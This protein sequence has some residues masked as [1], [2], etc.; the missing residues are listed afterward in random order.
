MNSDLNRVDAYEPKPEDYDELPELTDV[1][2]D[3]RSAKHSV[4]DA[5]DYLN[6]DTVIDEYLTA[7]CEDENPDVFLQAVADV[8]KA[9]GEPF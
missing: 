6:E 2:L 8:A 7:A 1:M 9:R 3:R 5:A 4:F